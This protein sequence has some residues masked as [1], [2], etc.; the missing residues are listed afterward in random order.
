MIF[1]NLK[2]QICLRSNLR[3]HQFF[4]RLKAKSK[5]T[6]KRDK[7]I[8]YLLDKFGLLYTNDNEE[9][10]YRAYDSW[11]LN[12]KHLC[13]VIYFFQILCF[14]LPCCD[15]G[16]LLCSSMHS[17]VLYLQQSLQYLVLLHVIRPRFLFWIPLLEQFFDSPGMLAMG[18]SYSPSFLHIFSFIYMT[19]LGGSSCSCNG[20]VSSS[21]NTL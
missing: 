20:Y 12:I 19:I 11:K 1:H 15:W 10:C 14:F 4:C 8:K 7:I 18:F 21:C 6:S 17:F 16:S 2:I 13:F 3:K 5:F 9:I